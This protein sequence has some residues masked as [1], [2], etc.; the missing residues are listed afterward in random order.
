MGGVVCSRTQVAS[1]G[2]TCEVL[3]R[4]RCEDERNRGE[5]SVRQ[6]AAPQH[7]LD[8]PAP[9][10]AIAVGKRVDRLE[11]RVC[12][13]GLRYSGQAVF[14]AERAEISH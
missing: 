13:C 12:K 9:G 8:Q 7:E 4:P 2:Q 6:P 14:V 11:L 10:P 1:G 5:Y 3:L